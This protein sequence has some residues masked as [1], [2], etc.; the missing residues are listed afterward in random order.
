[1]DDISLGDFQM[2]FTQDEWCTICNAKAPKEEFYR[3]W[4][5]KESIAKAG[6]CGLGIP[7]YE[8]KVSKAKTVL[9]DGVSWRLTRLD[10]F[11]GY[12]CHFSIE[13]SSDPGCMAYSESSSPSITD[14]DFYEV[15]PTDLLSG[16]IA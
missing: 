7:L 10:T 14:F 15:T 6:G 9:L 1:M 5:A 4:P 2:Q 3:F 13:D 8:V 12:A 16:R 11:S